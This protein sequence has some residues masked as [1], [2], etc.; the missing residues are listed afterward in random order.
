MVEDLGGL[1]WGARIVWWEARMGHWR[2][3]WGCGRLGKVVGCSD[4]MMGRTAGA[5][6]NLGW[7][8]EARYR[9]EGAWGGWWSE[10]CWRANGRPVRADGRFRWTGGMLGSRGGAGFQ[11]L[12]K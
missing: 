10:T 6:G 1:Q 3:V 2:P 4:G 12:R 9:T 5:V 11:V 8:W 7:W